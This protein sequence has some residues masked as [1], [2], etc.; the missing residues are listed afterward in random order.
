[1]LNILTHRWL[2][3][4]NK[5]SKKHKYW[6][7]IKTVFPMFNWYYSVGRCFSQ[8]VLGPNEV[9]HFC[10]SSSPVK[11]PNPLRREIQISQY[12][13]NITKNVVFGP[14]IYKIWLICVKKQA[15]FNLN[16]FLKTIVIIPTPNPTIFPR[17]L[18]RQKLI[19]NF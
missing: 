1:M 5:M 9:M 14:V 12:P 13:I 11:S 17:V 19:N 18:L 15:S 16:L 7:A 8:F 3:M 10:S 4:P 2:F 6:C